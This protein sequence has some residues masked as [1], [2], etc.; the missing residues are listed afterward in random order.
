[1]AKR[2]GGNTER[3]IKGVR[4]TAVGRKE[5]GMEGKQKLTRSALE[6]EQRREALAR[7]CEGADG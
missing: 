4:G 5:T 1:M 7:S 6:T 2:R 3:R